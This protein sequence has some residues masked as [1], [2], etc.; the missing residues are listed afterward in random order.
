MALVKLKRYLEFFQSNTKQTSC[1]GRWK[2]QLSAARSFETCSSHCFSNNRHFVW[3]LPA[4]ADADD[5]F[6]GASDHFEQTIKLSNCVNLSITAW[7]TGTWFYL[8]LAQNKANKIIL[9]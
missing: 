8:S 7:D 4:A 9:L 6:G 3:H 5:A 1:Y 2:K